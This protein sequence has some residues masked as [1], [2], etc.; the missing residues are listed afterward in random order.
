MVSYWHQALDLQTVIPG[1]IWRKEGLRGAGV[2]SGNTSPGHSNAGGRGNIEGG[3]GEKLMEG[4]AI[5]AA[6]EMRFVL[7]L[8]PT[9]EPV[10][11]P[12]RCSILPLLFTVWSLFTLIGKLPQF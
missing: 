12:I 10:T 7:L 3:A 11:D 1:E 2:M 4:L 6:F 8:L 9:L 5:S